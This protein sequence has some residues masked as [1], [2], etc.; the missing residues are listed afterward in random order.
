MSYAERKEITMNM[1]KEEGFEDG[2]NVDLEQL[3]DIV[4]NFTRREQ[5]RS[6]DGYVSG[7][8]WSAAGLAT[9]AIAIKL[10]VKYVR[11]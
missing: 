6:I 8:L 9:S 4:M 1:L 3:A 5:D 2:L 10:Y 7:V 11:K